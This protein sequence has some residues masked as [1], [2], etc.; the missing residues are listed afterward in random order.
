MNSPN[1][2]LPAAELTDGRP[3][4]HL[5]SILVQ[6]RNDGYM[7]N[8][9]WRLGTAI[10]NHA[11][12][13]RMLGLDAEVELLL[14]DWGSEVPLHRALD[15]SPEA[16]E[17]VRILAVPPQ[18]AKTFDGESRYSGVHPINAI[19][20]RARG[21]YVLFSDSD[22]YLPLD[23]FARLIYFLKRGDINGLSLD[24]HFFWAS[25]F[26]VP[27]NIVSQNLALPLLDKIIERE[28]PSFIQERVNKIEFIG[29][30]VGLLMPR[31]VWNEARGW[32]ERLIHWGWYDI[33]F[34][35]R[36]KK[37]FRWDLLEEHGMKFFHLEHYNGRFEGQ[38][39]TRENQQKTNAQREPTEF[40]PNP[41]SWG[42]GEC[43]L[44]FVD[45]HGRPSAGY[46]AP[47]TA[48][49][50]QAAP[51]IGAHREAAAIRDKWRLTAPAAR[52]IP[53]YR[54]L[55]EHQQPRSVCCISN[56]GRGGNAIEIAL[57]PFVE[58]VVCIDWQPEKRLG[59][60]AE[61]QPDH[62]T[63]R[64]F[65]D[66]LNLVDQAGVASKLQIIR[67]RSDAAAAALAQAGESFD[68][69]FFCSD[70]N[71][72]GMRT[73]HMAWFSLLK[74]GGVLG[75]TGGN[76]HCALHRA[77]ASGDATPA[78]MEWLEFPGVWVLLP[79]R[80]K[81]LLEPQIK[82]SLLNSLKEIEKLNRELH[83]KG[84]LPP[85]SPRVA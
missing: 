44:A 17:I 39:Q 71:L 43:A 12:N 61:H 64:E 27:K 49:L 82:E 74:K 69:I 40:T 65:E 26:H 5:L 54:A 21:R 63:N 72:E 78:D 38:S 14:V 55:L 36:L 81:P 80:L 20:R 79:Q 67:A 50:E 22:V 24:E 4:S 48:A 52:L 7:G 77:A 85:S 53:F 9:L 68:T 18:T 46:A 31:A 47:R 15:L 70:T 2:T 84:V 57:Y 33:D 13:I 16:R 59:A 8:F 76:F 10:N 25:K 19:A 3:S 42:L 29:F 37:R 83:E 58:R 30:G 56:D 35:R 1:A 28:W 73:D 75:G 6:G 23:S 51:L 34:H 45:G 60:T 66:F 41:V 32:D 11:R 62:N